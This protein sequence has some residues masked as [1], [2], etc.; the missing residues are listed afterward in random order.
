MERYAR[1]RSALVPKMIDLIHKIGKKQI[2]EK[3]L[4]EGHHRFTLHVDDMIRNNPEIKELKTTN[5][6]L[7]LYSFQRDERDQ[8]IEALVDKF[9]TDGFKITVIGK[10]KLEINWA[11][12]IEKKD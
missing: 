3:A 9:E 5:N 11:K 10:I 8:V 7:N 1:H 2:L 6:I 12:P 4:T